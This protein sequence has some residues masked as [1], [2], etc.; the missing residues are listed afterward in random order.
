MCTVSFISSGDKFIITSNRDENMHRASSQRPVTEVINGIRVTFPKDPR[1][2]GTWFAI[3]ENGTITVLLNGAFVKHHHTGNYA[4]SRGLILLEICG[5]SSPLMHFEEM[6]L[7]NIEPFTVILF[8]QARLWELRWD[9]N[10][11][12]RHD[13]DIRGNYIWSSSTLYSPDVIAQREELFA[14]FIERDQLDEMSVIDFHSNNHSDFQNGFI[15]DRN[16]NLKTLSITQ[17]VA[18]ENEVQL[19][20][21]DLLKNLRY[22]VPVAVQPHNFRAH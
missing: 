22:E 12:Y 2:G 1:A 16:E 4:R 19:A 21:H 9:G 10:K 17:A 14:A 7:E 20:H 13:L 8:D 11:K 15:I 6:D 3:N 5:T 18:Q